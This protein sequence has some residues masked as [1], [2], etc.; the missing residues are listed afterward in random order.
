[1]ASRVNSS[2]LKKNSYLTQ[3]FP[4]NREKLKHLPILL[5]FIQHF[6]YFKTYNPM[7]IDV[8]TKK[9][10]RR[11]DDPVKQEKENE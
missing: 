5:F 9:N 3:T 1:M 7:N 8:K 6:F 10:V 4:E 11:S 2:H